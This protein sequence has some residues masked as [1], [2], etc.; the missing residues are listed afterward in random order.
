MLHERPGLQQ[1][2]GR[3][4]YDPHYEVKVRN[5]LK[6]AKHQRV[7]LPGASSARGCIP[8]TEL[9]K[10]CPVVL[11]VAGLPQHLHVYLA[12]Q[13]ALMGVL[14]KRELSPLGIGLNFLSGGEKISPMNARVFL[15]VAVGGGRG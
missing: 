3:V 12:H 13:R 14:Y 5:D 6:G 10:P 9:P 2:G 15:V 11:E 8:Q 1:P 7:A 4:L